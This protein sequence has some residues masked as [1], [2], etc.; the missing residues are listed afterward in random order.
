MVFDSARS[1]IV[2]ID[3][4]QRRQFYKDSTRAVPILGGSYILYNDLRASVGGLW[5]VPAVG[6]SLP[7]KILS[8]PPGFPLMT[9]NDRYF[10]YIDQGI[11]W[12]LVLPSGKKERLPKSFPNVNAI[13]ISSDGSEIVYVER[14]DRGK[15][16]MYEN[17]FK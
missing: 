10:V 4:K 3:G 6:N 8:T 7:R 5:I 12:K 14:E 17:L 2:P 15:M 1:F 9:S 11:C 13:S 16:V